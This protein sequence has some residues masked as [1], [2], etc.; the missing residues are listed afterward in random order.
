MSPLA[1][2]SFRWVRMPWAMPAGL[3]RGWAPA[4]II[5]RLCPVT[6]VPA[7]SFQVGVSSLG[8]AS[9]WLLGHFYVVSLVGWPAVVPAV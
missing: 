3:T 5:S 4:P 7:E 6:P 8:S 1:E 9:L 2:H